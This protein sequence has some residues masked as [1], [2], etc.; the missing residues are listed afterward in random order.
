MSTTSSKNFTTLYSGSGSVTPQGAYGNANVV[1]LLA[2]GTDGANTVTTISATGNITTDAYFVGNF[3]GNITGNISVPGSNTQVLFNNSGN[4]GAAAGLTFDSSSNVLA[5][6]GSI[7]AVGNVQGNYFLGNGSQ[8]TGLP[9]TYG[10]SNVAA[11]MAAYGSNTISS[12]GN[13]TTTANI[14]GGYILGNGSQ[15]TGLPANYGNANVVALLAAFGSNTISTTGNVTSGNLITAGAVYASSLTGAAGQDVTITADGTN[16]INLDA[17]TVRIGDNNVDAVLTTHG[18]GNLTLKTDNASSANIIVRTG[19]NANVD[20]NPHGSG[21]VNA[22]V[23]S[24]TGNITASYFL[25]NGSQLTGLPATYS[26]ANVVS[27]LAAFGSNT[28]STTGNVDSGNLNATNVYSTGVVSATGNVRGGNVN[29]AGNVSLGGNITAAAG[30]NINFASAGLINPSNH[31]AY[32]G[33]GVLLGSYN[34][35]NTTGNAS[36]YAD[37]AVGNVDITAGGTNTWN[38]AGA[39]G[40]LTLPGNTSAINYANGVNILTSAA[41]TYGNANVADFLANG[42]GSNTISTTGNVS[43]GNVIVPNGGKYRGDFSAG[44]TAGRT[45]FQTTGTGTT[46]T[47]LITAIPGV[48][49]VAVPGQF[50]TATG[51]FSTNDM[52]N[53]SI[54][55]MYSY[56]TEAQ[57]RSTNTG[58]GNVNDVTFR[59]GSSTTLAATITAAGLVSAVG[60]VQGANLVT[61]G[62]ATVSGNVIGGNLI[63]AGTV[64]ASASTANVLLSNI[65]ITSQ[66]TNSGQQYVA[67]N[68]P[69][70]T[71]T[72]TTINPGRML[73][74]NGFQG[75]VSNG[76]DAFNRQTKSRFG[77]WDTAQLPASFSGAGVNLTSTAQYQLAGNTAAAARLFSTV[78]FNLVAS[79]GTGNTFT[80]AGTVPAAVAGFNTFAIAGNWVG[81]T[82]G[83]MAN[84]GNVIVNTATGGIFGTIV[85]GGSTMG[86][87][88]GI[89]STNQASAAAG[90][91]AT[92]NN[93]IYF[94]AW[95]SLTTAGTVT[96]PGNVFVYHNPGVTNSYGLTHS[97]VMRASTNYYFLRNDDDVA[98]VKLGS[99]RSYHEYQYATATSGTVNIDKTNSQV[100]FIAPTGNITIGDLQ[101]FV[102]TANDGT[103]NDS[104]ADTVTLII[105]QGATPY[106]VTMPTGN[107]SIKY[108][109]NVSTISTTANSVTMVS[110]TAYRTAANAAMYLTTISPEFV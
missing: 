53:A 17:D 94:S 77:F 16:N 55:G 33:A 32:S 54:F 97:N 71:V 46:A 29:T 40:N 42:F 8:L 61:T 1:S 62:L 34:T 76:V 22:T 96:T 30:T 91:T 104:Q 12:T 87:S 18:S 108:A 19:T 52:G 4:V 41:G 110:I 65:R 47:T 14:S 51:L 27:L 24:A 72:N 36:V 21:I 35:G 67:V 78:N 85:N 2:A 25:G 98:Q 6:S 7:T 59:F 43:T 73:F 48:N 39:T 86:N 75:N 109:A 66:A 83:G 57:I 10:N 84:V 15:L 20:L 81:N 3:A 37:G 11:F 45:V 105:Q 102:T 26:N 103:N 49:H 70:Y 101:N 93:Q 90:T 63:T 69:D 68:A 95:D 74:G 31:L 50:G 9:A 88:F 58:T 80:S 5:T 13:I 64:S 28:I 100:Q 92:I 89:V 106:T 107:A 99:L 44:P 82:A 60:N 23:L 56:P 38:F 79:E